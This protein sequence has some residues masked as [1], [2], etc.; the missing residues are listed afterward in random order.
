M[1]PFDIALN[2][3]FLYSSFYLPSTMAYVSL[4]G[5]SAGLIRLVSGHP[6]L[7]PGYLPD[8]GC[9]TIVGTSLAFLGITGL[10][11]PASHHQLGIT[12]LAS[13]AWYHRLTW[14]HWASVGLFSLPGSK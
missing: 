9:L 13:P 4:F 1:L 2:I 7:L 6:P 8:R 14:H 11:L 10:V 5:L 12:G 3:A